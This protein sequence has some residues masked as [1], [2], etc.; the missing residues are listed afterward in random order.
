[1]ERYPFKPERVWV[2]R[3]VEGYARTREMLERLGGVPVTVVDD[4]HALK[5]IT[6]LN[7]AKQEWILT[8]H[9]GR[10]FKPC[11]GMPID[12]EHICCGY[13]VIDLV[14]GCPMDCSYCILQHYLENN[15]R[16]AIY[17]NIEEILEEVRAFLKLNGSRSLR[18]GTGELG[19]SLA[20]DPLTGHASEL[21]PFFAEQENVVLELKTKTDLVDH[22][23]HLPHGGRTVIAWSM[24]TERI[25]HHEERGS[26]SLTQRFA[27]AR[28]CVDAG[29]RVGF[30]FDPLVINSGSSEEI[31]EYAD[32]IDRIFDA[33]PAERIAWVSLG[34]LRLPYAMKAL[35]Q[36][37]FPQTTIFSGEIVPAGGKMRY[38][39]F[40]RADFYRPLWD[41]LTRRLPPEKVYLCME[42]REVWQKLG[43]TSRR[44]MIGG[45]PSGRIPR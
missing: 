11:Q 40:L 38:A 8:K 13:H 21:I 24:N 44:G 10:A 29:Y 39:K 43:V 28:K 41:R 7:K 36:R 17:V 5:R 45:F 16:T 6:D 19:D 26:A 15:P 34:L 42:T 37:R 22:L 18:I 4:V 33:V 35:V 12:D 31:A 3:D 30:H 32:V 20:L 27:A 9:H 25:V 14:S 1:M 23:L 2:D